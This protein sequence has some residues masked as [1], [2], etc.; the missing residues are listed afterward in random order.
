VG[1]S[2]GSCPELDAGQLAETAVGLGVGLV[3][4]RAGKGHAWES[5]GVAPLLAAGLGVAFVGTSLVL[6]RPMPIREILT[7]LEA[8]GAGGLPVKVFADAEVARQP[9]AARLAETQARVIQDWSGPGR[10]LVETHHGYAAPP[11]L[12]RLCELTG[13]RVLLDTLGLARLGTPVHTAGPTLAGYLAAAQVKGYD[14]AAAGAGGHRPLATMSRAHAAAL[15][16]MLPPGAP[17][18]VESRAGT[19]AEDLTVLRRWLAGP[20][21][22]AAPAE[23]EET[24]A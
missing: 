15:D 16:R 17:A 12:A 4:L 10:L 20:T 22:P 8:L 9:E 5:G 1:L 23:A 19:L 14:E 11:S 13:C 18:L 3:D 24:H 6:G 2:G 21:G 7:A